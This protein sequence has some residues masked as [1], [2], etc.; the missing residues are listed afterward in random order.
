MFDVSFYT[1]D[2]LNK[3]GF[4]G[5]GRNVKISKASVVVGAGNISIGDNTR[6]DAFSILSASQGGIEIGRNVHVAS[7]CSIQG[8]GGVIL[9]DFAGLSHGV[10]L[11]SVSDDYSGTSLTNPTIPEKYL[12]KKS[13]LVLLEKHVIIGANAVILPD[14]KVGMGSAVGALSL[15]SRNLAPLGVYSGIPARLIKSRAQNFLSLADEFLLE[16]ADKETKGN[17]D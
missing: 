2:E 15:V 17:N 1:P 12:N 11:F 3:L 14:V 13:G 4:K 7:F 10:K 6:I 8:S 16:E 9:E 5:L